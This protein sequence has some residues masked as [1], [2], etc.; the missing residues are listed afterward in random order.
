MAEIGPGSMI[1]YGARVD[2]EE[3][4]QY[5]GP[6]PARWLTRLLR[7]VL[8]AAISTEGLHHIIP[9]VTDRIN[10]PDEGVD[11][12]LTVNLPL[13][14]QRTP[15]LVNLG[16][17]IYQIKWRSKRDKIFNA[18]RGELRDLKNRAGLPDYYVFVT[19]IILS[20]PDHKRIRI[21]LRQDCEEFPPDRIIVLGA[22]ELADRINNDPRIR[23]AHFEVALGI[24]TL[25]LAREY[26][27]RRW[28]NAE[29][30]QLFNRE[31]EISSLRRF[32]H[33]P[34]DRVCVVCGAEGVGKSRVVIEALSDIPE[35][36][37]WARESPAQAAGLLQ[38]LDESPY[39][40]V[41]V[42]DNVEAA[43]DDL[44][45][46]ALE[47]SRL[48]T[49]VVTLWPVSMPGVRELPL[50]AFGSTDSD[51]LLASVFPMMATRG[52][53]YNQFGGLPGLLL[54]GATAL[55]GGINT[56]P[57][58]E[59][60]YET[61][62]QAY[63]TRM[64]RGLDT[65]ATEALTV[66]A[67]LP[68]FKLG[69]DSRRDLELIAGHCAID[70]PKVLRA[71]NVL[72]RRYLVE[73]YGIYDEGLFRVTPPLLAKQIAKRVIQSI[74]DELPALYRSLSPDGQTG[75]TRRMGELQ[76][77]PVV[78]PLLRI[79]LSPQGLFRDL[80]SVA[81]N[82]AAIRALAETMPAYAGGMLRQVLES[83]TVE[84]RRIRLKGNARREIVHALE[85]LVYRRETFD[86][87]AIGLLCLAEGENEDYATNATDLFT[88]IFHWRYSHIPKDASLRSTLLRSLAESDDPTR[89]LLVAKA[90]AHC[91]ETQFVIYHQEEQGVLPPEPGWRA[92]RWAEVHDAVRP[93]VGLL[94]LLTLDSNLAVRHEAV[95]GLSRGVRGILAVGLLDEAVSGLEFLASESLDASERAKLVEGVA[96]TIRHLKDA[97]P[98]AGEDSRAS[99]HGYITRG[100]ALF[101]RLTS[102]DFRS[103]FLH[104]LGP[105]PLRAHRRLKD[106]TDRSVILTEAKRLAEEVIADPALLEP[107]LSDWIADEQ[108][109]NAGSFLYHLG[110][111]DK[112][113]LWL[114]KLERRLEKPRGV[115]DV[116]IY[117]AGY[118]S[119][120]P[121]KAGDYLDQIAGKGGSWSNAAL[122]A[123]LRTEG[124]EKGVKRLLR[125]INEGSLARVYVAQTLP[126]RP[127]VEQLTIDDFLKLITALRNGTA[128][129]D[130]E[131]LEVLH[132]RWLARR[133]ERDRLGPIIKEILFNAAAEIA[134]THEFYH[135]DSLAAALVEWDEHS[136]F[137]LLLSYL[138][139]EK[140]GRT[141]FLQFDL[142]EFIPESCTGYTHSL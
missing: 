97:V 81:T 63:E 4:E 39:S 106:D 49:I 91:L 59:A 89:R 68:K 94:K 87:G 104:W 53:L 108:A 141:I 34:S 92:T 139:R 105:T 100:E 134:P 130:W 31:D 123:T 25:D 117:V 11:A 36:V 45:R 98:K 62:L 42:V 102:A 27:E 73:Q 121:E 86:D 66:L 70:L 48:K 115:S 74:G 54:L 67:V 84:D 103:R 23:I 29:P 96:F 40:A 125:C 109:Q 19:N 122:D 69:P 24:C 64:T 37:V 80:H 35:Q 57:L 83:A 132:Q 6:D 28:G 76:D 17:T 140:R 107:D 77:E 61:I 18:A 2:A 46:K 111:L 112:G 124:S 72:K 71:F 56:D 99:L 10:T 33:S 137:E 12:R 113:E 16:K 60:S 119:V 38:V 22:S 30:P 51:R 101:S 13:S 26:S 7:S 95:S 43:S 14:S 15:G 75:L 127:W 32:L 47:M 8:M 88:K 136:G 65:A 128:E 131:L 21:Q 82:S 110:S 135:W 93:V 138:R 50:K 55:A 116:G 129:I 52:W 41:L 20:M 85:T 114:E 120:D 90:A 5:H 118:F 126:W 79:L 9:E 3:I 1:P 142:V 58:D 133:E 44:L 78:H